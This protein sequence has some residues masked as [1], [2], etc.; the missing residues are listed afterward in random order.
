M[1]LNLTS[2]QH[3]TSLPE[4]TPS[5]EVPPDSSPGVFSHP[6]VVRLSQILSQAP[7]AIL[8]ILSSLPGSPA[9][10]RVAAQSPP[11]TQPRE[12]TAGTLFNRCHQQPPGKLRKVD[13]LIPVPVSGEQAQGRSLLLLRGGLLGADAPM[14]PAPP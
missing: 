8:S 6:Q 3:Q 13:T 7:V 10:P 1:G 11:P 5:G 9:Q 4:K 2:K 14:S 12:R